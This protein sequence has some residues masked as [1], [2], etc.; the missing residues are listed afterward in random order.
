MAHGR[1]V[2]RVNPTRWHRNAG[3]GGGGRLGR[4]IA[5]I[6]AIKLVALVAIK[7]AW[8]S[9]PPEPSDAAVAQTLL[10]PPKAAQR[11]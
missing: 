10:G 9:D 6:V 5:L 1:A 11:E 7:L 8:F 3:A 4:D 2:T